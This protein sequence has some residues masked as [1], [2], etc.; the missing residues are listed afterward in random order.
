MASRVRRK[1]VRSDQQK[2]NRLKVTVY[3]YKDELQSIE[4]AASNLEMT[5]SGYMAL[6]AK[7]RAKSD[8]S[9]KQ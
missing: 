4:T 3:L 7:E 2:E 8:L 6:S 5:I 9:K 1:R